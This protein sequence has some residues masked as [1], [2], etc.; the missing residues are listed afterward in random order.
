MA[1]RRKTPAS[2]AAWI[3]RSI[4]LPDTVARVWARSPVA[5]ADRDHQTA[6]R[7]DERGG[8]GPSWAHGMNRSRASARGG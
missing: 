7:P 6:H 1:K 4:I 3:E 8:M 2:L 5:V